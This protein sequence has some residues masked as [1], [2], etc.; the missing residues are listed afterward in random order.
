MRDDP[1]N[2]SS[3]NPLTNKPAIKNIQTVNEFRLLLDEATKSVRRR[4]IIHKQPV[5]ISEN[6][7]IY[8]IYPDGKK[9]PQNF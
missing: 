4:T 3:M 9:E 5:A 6:G 8:L 1:R 2:F 7:I